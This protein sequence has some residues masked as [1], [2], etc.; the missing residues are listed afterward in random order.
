MNT[1]RKSLLPARLIYIGVWIVVA[2]Y[3]ALAEA[4]WVSTGYVKPDATVEY[5]LHL[6]CVLFTLCGTWGA[7]RLLAFKQVRRTLTA[8]PQKLPQFNLV[9]TAVLGTAILINLLVYYA[10]LSGT[11]P[12]YCLLITLLAFVFCWPKEGEIEEDSQEGRTKTR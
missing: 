12:L 7:L 6:L 9:R 2:V 4:G 8:H 10:L 11:A 5:A 1:D 3:A